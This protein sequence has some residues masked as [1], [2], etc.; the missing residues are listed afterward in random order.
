MANR[1]TGD[2]TN[3]KIDAFFETFKD[4]YHSQSFPEGKTYYDGTVF[5]ELELYWRKSN[6]DEADCGENQKP[7]MEESIEIALKSL[8]LDS[9]DK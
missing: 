5:N 7:Q 6:S 3:D 9:I 1:L 4:I 8:S 2:D